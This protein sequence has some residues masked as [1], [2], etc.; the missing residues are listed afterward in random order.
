[1][2]CGRLQVYDHSIHRA[3]PLAHVRLAAKTL[4]MYRFHVTNLRLII[5][6]AYPPKTAAIVPAY[7]E[8][9]A[10]ITPKPEAGMIL[11]M[12]VEDVTRSGRGSPR[13][14]LYNGELDD[15]PNNRAP[16]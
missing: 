5:R 11:G 12:A 7:F 16:I 2:R 13:G 6:L 1:M 3:G 8:N 14:K 4:T 9:M 10:G 15:T